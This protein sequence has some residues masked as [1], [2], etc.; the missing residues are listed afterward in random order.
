LGMAGSIVP[1][2]KAR[3]LAYSSARQAA[4]WDT[5]QPA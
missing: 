2:S 3:A 1:L 5:L 4:I